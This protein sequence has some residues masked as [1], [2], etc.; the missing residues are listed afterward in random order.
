VVSEQPLSM[1]AEELGEWRG[2]WRRAPRWLW[3]AGAVR[4]AADG[5]PLRSAC[6]CAA[7][8]DGVLLSALRGRGRGIGG[9][10]P[11]TAAAVLVR[12]A[13]HGTPAPGKGAPV[14]SRP[15][16]GLGQRLRRLLE[17]CLPPHVL[18]LIESRW[19]SKSLAFA[20]KLRP[21]RLNNWRF[22]LTRGARACLCVRPSTRGASTRASSCSARRPAAP[23]CGTR[24]RMPPRPSP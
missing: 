21:R 7:G 24:R 10:A 22:S 5:A 18:R 13:G 14:C 19:V 8:G 16:P 17:V 4:A 12:D 23:P 6:A 3:P 2:A 20:G 15:A 9:A 1:G 11:G